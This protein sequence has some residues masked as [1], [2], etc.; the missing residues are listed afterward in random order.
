[1]NNE[2]E[3][4]LVWQIWR[5]CSGKE[6][7]QEINDFFT[8]TWRGERI[9]RGEEHWFPRRANKAVATV[10]WVKL[11]IAKAEMALMLIKKGM[12]GKYV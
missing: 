9:S 12:E 8:K 4:G 3:A 11:T 6:A 5:K 10:S 2:K 7:I 1:M